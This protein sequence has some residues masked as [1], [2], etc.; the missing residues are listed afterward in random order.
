MNVRLSDAMASRRRAQTIEGLRGLA[1]RSAPGAPGGRA[2]GGAER[3]ATAPGPEPAAGALERC[4]LCHVAIGAEHR[5]LLQ[6]TERRILCACEPC[7][8]MRAG[9][10][11]LRPT[12]QR[13]LWL[14]GFDL[15]E[16]V[17]ADLR[18]PIGLAFFMVSS[19]TACVVAMYPSPAGA[20]E[21]EL[22]FDT[23]RAVAERNPVL[24]AM[25]ADIEGLIVNRI[26]EPPVY[27]IAPI[28]RCYEL[29]GLIKASWEGISGG[30]SVVDAVGGFFSTLRE[31]A[32][33]A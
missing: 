8:A 24:E 9:D 2:P 17:W 1:L 16:E 33:V 4:D 20:T 10:E 13:T 11:D 27:A 15:P 26:A 23:W 28:D 6:L 7:W 14:E 32:K 18:I 5:H 21:S 22:H 3:A 19:V 29:T 25:E 30:A 31:E 12:G